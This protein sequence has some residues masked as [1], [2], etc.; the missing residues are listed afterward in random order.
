[1]INNGVKYNREVRL[2]ERKR[3]RFDD[4]LYRKCYYFLRYNFYR[5]A[6]VPEFR[7]EAEAR[8]LMEDEMDRAETIIL[9]TP[10]RP[11]R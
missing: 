7:L 1:M 8:G 5:N 11:Q 2:A 6:I 3:E 10:C 4:E 9:P